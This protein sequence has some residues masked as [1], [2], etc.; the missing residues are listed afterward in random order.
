MELNNPLLVTT[1]AKI[2]NTNETQARMGAPS[3]KFFGFFRCC[4]NA[5]I[6][7][8]SINHGTR[9]DVSTG[10]QLQKPPQPSTRYAQIPPTAIPRVKKS[11]VNRLVGNASFIQLFS[12]VKRTTTAAAKG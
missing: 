4:A 8:V 11:Q 2:I 7:A 12:P 10:S 5:C 9:D 3:A 1:A 6:N